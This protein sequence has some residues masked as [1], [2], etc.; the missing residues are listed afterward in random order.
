MYYIYGLTYSTSDKQSD[1]H[2]HEWK[3]ITAYLICV[4]MFCATGGRCSVSLHTIL[5][6]YIESSGDFLAKM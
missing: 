3:V 1:A 6:D 4:I 5:S 2:V